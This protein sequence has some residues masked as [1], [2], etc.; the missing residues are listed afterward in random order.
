[1]PDRPTLHLGNHSGRTYHGPGRRWTAMARPRHFERGEGTIWTLAPESADLRAVKA[2]TLPEADYFARY[3]ARLERDPLALAQLQPG[4]LTATLL[5]GVGAAIVRDGDS[6]LCCCSRDAALAGRCHLAVATPILLRAGWR[7]RLHGLLAVL[8]ADGTLGLL[9]PWESG[10][11]RRWIY[12]LSK[13]MEPS[14]ACA[15]RDFG[16]EVEWDLWLPGLD[17]ATTYYDGGSVLSRGPGNGVEAGIRADAALER[18]Q[19]T[20]P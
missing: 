9:G 13:D 11:V 15:I 12:P 5:D 20:T 7:V 14:T 16:D 10:S 17:S 6:A 3:R 18:M 2:G 4:V 8:G 19:E 1:M